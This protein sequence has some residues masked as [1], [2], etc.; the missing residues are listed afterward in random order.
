MSEE[1]L[2]PDARRR[3]VAE[4]SELPKHFPKVDIPSGVLSGFLDPPQSPSQWLFAQ[5]TTCVSAD[6]ST[7]IEPC[8]FGG[9]PVCTECGC[10]ASASLSVVCRHKR[11]GLRPISGIAS[12]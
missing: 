6:L 1:R 3:A 9:R 2:T 5:T 11:A 8:Q 10:M 12:L 7:R 4:L